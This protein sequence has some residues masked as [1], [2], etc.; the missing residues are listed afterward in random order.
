[1]S[2]HYISLLKCMNYPQKHFDKKEQ[3]V[4]GHRYSSNEE[5]LEMLGKSLVV[6]KWI[7]T[8]NQSMFIWHFLA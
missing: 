5:A 4:T 1:M 2:S 8:F 7:L 6:S 3:N